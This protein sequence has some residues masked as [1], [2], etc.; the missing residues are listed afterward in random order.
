MKLFFFLT[1]LFSSFGE[2]L[3]GYIKKD[4]LPIGGDVRALLCWP[5]RW[6]SYAV[7]PGQLGLNQ[8]GSLWGR[9]LASGCLSY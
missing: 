7:P 1:F 6:V 2:M 9:G 3:V 8:G 5:I 4:R